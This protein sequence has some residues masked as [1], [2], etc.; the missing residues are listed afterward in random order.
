MEKT[1]DPASFTKL[2]KKKV[3]EIVKAV[4]ESKYDFSDFVPIS[5]YEV[6]GEKYSKSITNG[7]ESCDPS[8]A[9]DA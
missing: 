4:L 9:C 7:S 3:D 1:K 5:V 8:C 6:L 2:M